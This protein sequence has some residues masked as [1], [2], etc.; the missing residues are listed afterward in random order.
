VRV[1]PKD[2]ITQLGICAVSN[3]SLILFNKEKYAAPKKK[4]LT[5]TRKTNAPGGK[6]KKRSVLNSSDSSGEDEGLDLNRKP[7][8][9]KSKVGSSTRKKAPQSNRRGPEIDGVAD[10][11]GQMGRAD[12]GSNAAADNDH[13]HEDEAMDLVDDGAED[14]EVIDL[15][16]EDTWNAN[17]DQ[18]TREGYQALNKHF[19]LWVFD[20]YNSTEADSADQKPDE[21]LLHKECLDALQK[22]AAKK[23]AVGQDATISKTA[24]DK[25]CRTCWTTVVQGDGGIKL[26]LS[27]VSRLFNYLDAASLDSST[28]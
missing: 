28:I 11:V 22:I 23:N 24:K 25:N 20:Q 18:K 16:V 8:A 14:D 19:V 26:D 15:V 7:A 10:V 9:K 27:R 12:R 4:G 17:V 3:P 1:F 6:K 13:E 2:K 21:R 5:S